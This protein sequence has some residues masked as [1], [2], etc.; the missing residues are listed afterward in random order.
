MATKYNATT[1]EWEEQ[2]D[3]VAFPSL[4]GISG[5]SDSSTSGLSTTYNSQSSTPS[6]S[7]P[8][9][10]TSPSYNIE[11]T[12]DYLTRGDYRMPRSFSFGDW[13]VGGP[14]EYRSP[15]GVWSQVTETNTPAGYDPR[16]DSGVQGSNERLRF[17][18]AF[19]NAPSGT[20]IE[21]MQQWAT[22]SGWQEPDR[23]QG[24]MTLGNLFSD[25]AP[26]ALAMYGGVN[27]LGALGTGAAAGAADLAAGDAMA[28]LIPAGEVGAWSGL[29]AGL[30]ELLGEAGGYGFNS[31]EIPG[32]LP[33]F[34]GGGGDLLGSTGL[35]TLGNSSFGGPTE[36]LSP[37][38]T[39]P[40]SYSPADGS[41]PFATVEGVN[42]DWNKLTGYGLDNMYGKG[43][44]GIPSGTEQEIKNMFGNLTQ[45]IGGKRSGAM[46]Q[47]PSPLSML[48][49]GGKAFMD[50]NSQ[51][52]AANQY[53]EQLNRA[54]NYQD[55]NRA[56][57]DF[58]NKAWQQN[59]ENPM[60]GYRDFMAG[61]G[62]E[63]IDQARAKAAASGRRGSYVNSG[64]MN[65]DLA[66]L[67]MKNQL[68]RA[69]QLRG[70]FENGV[71]QEA[72]ALQYMEP[73]TRMTQN[74]FA[75][76]GQAIDKIGRQFTLADIFGG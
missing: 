6:V 33:E 68:D 47:A 65:S 42:K 45:P 60:A 39:L 16:Q 29:E 67:Y 40:D 66:S 30:P 15:E 2:D 36:A 9:S 34:L 11:T 50:Y 12:P 52:D 69:A 20:P 72:A 71:N 51:Q 64:R 17:D 70:G 58:A 76:F 35:E 38:I 21:Q 8:L 57:G 61:T 49:Q 53:K 32:N 13:H 31:L 28:G 19:R 54:R 73:L 18:Q 22:S 48:Y 7:K 59:F 14:L 62:R 74:K 10:Q 25:I 43:S 46:F 75:P 3:E 56:R 26:Y 63:F 5:I 44:F 24:G 37:E 4:G 1:G 41:D 27:A 23:S 55:P